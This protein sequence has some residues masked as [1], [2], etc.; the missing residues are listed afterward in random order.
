MVVRWFFR[1]RKDERSCFPAWPQSFRS[2]GDGNDATI[3]A[4]AP[5]ER[6]PRWALVRAHSAAQ[7]CSRAWFPSRPRLSESGWHTQTWSWIDSGPECFLACIFYSSAGIVPEH[8]FFL[9]LFFYETTS[10]FQLFLKSIYHT[11]VNLTGDKQ[12][13]NKKNWHEMHRQ[14]V[15]TESRPPDMRCLSR[16]SSSSLSFSVLPG[17]MLNLSTN[18]DITI[19]YIYH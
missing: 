8:F 19:Y 12:A 6:R 16:C 4:V 5:W 7:F 13:I 9:Q 10:F 15:P 2:R 18:E 14:F 3:K 1:G 17:H 11:S